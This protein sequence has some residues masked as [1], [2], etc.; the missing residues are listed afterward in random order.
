[1]NKTTTLAAA[2]AELRDGMT[3]GI[4]GWG[5]RRKPMAVVREMLR[6]PV[7]DLTVVS[8]GGPDVGLLCEAGKLQARRLR[9][10]VA[11]LDSPRS[12]LPRG[13]PSRRR[14]VPGARR[15]HVP[16][17]ALRGIAPPAVP[18]DARRPRQQRAR[19]QSGAEAG[20]LALRGRRRAGRDA[21]A[22]ARRRLHPHEPRRRQGQR[23]VSSAPT[24][25]S[26]TCSAWPRSAASCRASGSSRPES[27]SLAASVHTLRINRTHGRR[28]DRGAGRRALHRVSA[29]LRPRRGLPA[30]I[31][32]ER[33][34]RGELAALQGRVAR[35]VRSRVSGE[36]ACTED[37][38]DERRDARRDLR[39]RDRPTIS[40]ATARSWS[41]ASAACPRWARASRSS[42]SRRTC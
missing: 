40:A 10:R 30:R 38:I 24:S 9:L 8:Y 27:C 29:R 13:A 6:S 34:R 26:T 3:V 42:P 36:A 41:R 1:M 18:A 23:A 35:R 2:V 25:T 15:G 17:G 4:G 12:A 37:G 11:R 16:V 22:R 33:E 5:S 20:S 32:G 39:G 14:R 19:D 28:R 7:K 21:R 31:R